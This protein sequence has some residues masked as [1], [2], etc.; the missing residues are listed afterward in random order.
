MDITTAVKTCFNKYADFTGRARRSE[1]WWFFL[2]ITVVSIILTFIDVSIFSGM[3]AEIGVLS[4][5]FGLATLIPSLAVGARRLHD[6]NRSGWWQL[7][8]L[9]PFLGWLVVIYFF[10][11]KGDVGDNRFGADPKA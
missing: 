1:L 9:I 2:A 11:V 4:T 8:L 7:L 3:A 10:I 6:T 5:I